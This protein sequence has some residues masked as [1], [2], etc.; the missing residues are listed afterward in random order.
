MRAIKNIMEV[1]EI[2]IE[3]AANPFTYQQSYKA[4]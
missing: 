1:Y 4:L 3:S 2:E